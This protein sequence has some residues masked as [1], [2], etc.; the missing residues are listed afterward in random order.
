MPET[1]YTVS[2]CYKA[3]V[4]L[5]TAGT[6][7]LLAVI[8]CVVLCINSSHWVWTKRLMHAGDHGTKRR[9][10]D[11]LCHTQPG[12]PADLQLHHSGA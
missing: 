7:R 8:T 1:K 3:R 11:S 12:V 10:S 4:L 6:A 2:D 9:V 5:N